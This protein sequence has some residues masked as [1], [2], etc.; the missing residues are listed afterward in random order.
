L[1]AFHDRQLTDRREATLLSLYLTLIHFGGI[2]VP[3]GYTDPCK[4]V[5]GNP[6]GASLVA[7][8][9]NITDIDDATANALEHL[10]RRVVTFADRLAS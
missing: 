5:D 1:L 10:A 2:I 7:T 4:F 8:H 9:D 3:P 6:Y